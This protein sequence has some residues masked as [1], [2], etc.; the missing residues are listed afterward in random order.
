MQSAHPCRHRC[1]QGKA[2]KLPWIDHQMGGKAVI[3]DSRPE[4]GFSTHAACDGDYASTVRKNDNDFDKDR[5]ASR[6]DDGTDR[7]YGRRR[8][9][10]KQGTNGPQLLRQPFGDERAVFARCRRALRSTKPVALYAELI[11]GAARATA[12][13]YR[14]QPDA[15]FAA[16]GFLCSAQTVQGKA[17]A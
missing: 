16:P 10:G 9:F 4:L 12:H 7:L 13:T 14:F 2:T 8:S 3:L 6:T 11:S 1:R 5:A 15:A 17:P